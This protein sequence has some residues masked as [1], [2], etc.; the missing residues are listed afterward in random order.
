MQADRFTVKSQEAVQAAQKK[1]AAMTELLDQI[2]AQGC[3]I[4]I[5]SSHRT[6]G[7]RRSNSG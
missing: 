7:P 1:A 6:S 4:E 3:E 2:A 5:G